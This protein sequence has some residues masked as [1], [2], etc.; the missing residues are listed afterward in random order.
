MHER[1]RTGQRRRVVEQPDVHEVVWVGAAVSAQCVIVQEA[2]GGTH[3]MQ[4]GR[5]AEVVQ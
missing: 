5:D 2:R 1:A 4:E 3:G